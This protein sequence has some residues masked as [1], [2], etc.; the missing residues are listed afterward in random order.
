MTE[1]VAIKIW[2][3]KQNLLPMNLSTK[4]KQSPRHREQTY[5]CRGGGG[6]GGRG[7]DWEFGISRCKLLHLEWISHKVLPCNTG[8]S[9]QSLGRDHDGRKYEKKNVY[10]C[11]TGSLCWTAGI[12][13]TLE[14]NYP[15]T[16][17]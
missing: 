4:Q 6:G 3:Y 11:M 15:S 7:M 1:I 2:P 12:G 14:I 9:I 5:G 8:N 13:T 17:L 10:I 16:I